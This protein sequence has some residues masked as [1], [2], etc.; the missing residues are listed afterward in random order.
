MP[1]PMGYREI[2]ADLRT[3]IEGGEY[4]RGEPLPTYR[5]LAAL[6]SVGITTM[7]RAIRELMFEGLVVGRQGKHLYVTEDAAP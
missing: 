6:Y 4:K 5:E 3:R 7:Q 2:A 1:I